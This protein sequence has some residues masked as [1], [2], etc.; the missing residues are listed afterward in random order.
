MKIH[1]VSYSTRVNSPEPFYKLSGWAYWKKR[2]QFWRWR[3]HKTMGR[4]ILLLRKGKQ[5]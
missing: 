2:L 3:S 1:L 5:A 4:P